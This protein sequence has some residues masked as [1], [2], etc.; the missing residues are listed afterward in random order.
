MIRAPGTRPR[1]CLVTTGG[2]I[3]E[4][5]APARPRRHLSADELLRSLS[6]FAGRFDVSTIDLFDVPSTFMTFG[7]MLELAHAVDAALRDGAAGVVVTHGTDTLEETAYFVDL[8]SGET[9]PVVFTGA[10]LPPE[11][12]GADGALNLRHAFLV[13]GAPQARGQGVLVAMAAEV[14]AA[15]DVTK[16]HSTSLSAFR[17]PGLGP[18]GVI[19]E[20][21][22]VFHRWLPPTR[23][24]PISAVTARV[25]GVK[26]YADMSDV[27]IR[28]LVAAGF[29]GIVLETLGS[30][31]VPPGIV[32]A[33]RDAVRAGVTV[34]ATSRCAAGGLL[35]EHYGL[36]IRVAG[37]ERDLLEAGVVFSD[38]RGPKARIKLAV[39]LS[40]GLTGGEVRRFFGAD[41]EEATRERP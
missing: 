15:R 2:T 10:M 37:D 24:I 22:V 13:A 14:H 39:A 29:D 5:A 6:T 9:G 36:P 3:G 1:I 19:E 34:V 12:P 31:Q 17:S 27:P 32:P 33:I 25:E 35:R 38:L 4:R 40:A 30:G 21:R 28:A 16:A 20:D 18:V 7:Q 11:L 41:D 8:V 23:R 26:C